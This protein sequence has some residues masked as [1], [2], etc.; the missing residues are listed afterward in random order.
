[1]RTLYVNHTSRVSGGEL[2]LLTL[3]GGLPA[4]V[5]PLLACPAGDLARRAGAI[6]LEV[7]TIPG[8]DASLRL[9]PARTPRALL[10][11][12]RA[13][14]AI[15]RAAAA[16]EVD[17]VHANSIRAGLVVTAAGAP[18]IVHV[19]DCLPPGPLTS[20]TLRVIGRAD[21]LVANSEHTRST[22]GPAVV[23][24]RVIYNPVR[25]EDFE[26]VELTTAAARSRIGVEG[27]GPVLAMI[28]QITPWKGQ[29]DAIRIAELLSSS[30]PGLRLVLVGS[31]KF[32]SAA[33]RYDNRAYLASLERQ[34]EAAGLSE[35]VV[36]LGERDDIPQI[37][38]AADLL[39]AP[40]WEEPFGR[41][42]VE[43]MAAGVPVVATS[44]GGPPEILVD[45]GAE[46]GVLLPPRS[47]EAWATEVER[48]LASPT[49]RVQMTER[50][51]EAA[52][53]RFSVE[54]HANS[55]VALYEELLA[56][57]T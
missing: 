39:L 17:V 53:R 3:L 40:S 47:P 46:C 14:L 7:V 18:A 25:L 21:A 16:N 43:A 22:L 45:E 56:V 57:S 35:R 23:K 31:A 13:A 54:R 27:S 51:R 24:A 33:T 9:H 48:L 12:G 11:L 30:H 44:V 26:R 52:R 15:R 29:A 38:R 20:L 42:I 8:T 5:E 32:D 4:N 2:S 19:R 36:F 55:I 50:A 6:G 1:V 10:E 49:Q 28:A 34:V 37:L 41:S